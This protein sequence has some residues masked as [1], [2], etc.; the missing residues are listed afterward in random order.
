M[1]MLKWNT[2]F[3]YLAFDIFYFFSLNYFILYKCWGMKVSYNLGP[4]EF[5]V[6]FPLSG[7]Y[8]GAVLS[9]DGS[10]ILPLSPPGT[11]GES[12]DFL[13][14]TIGRVLLASTSGG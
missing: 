11:F 14:A 4:L 9:Q 13:I 5:S 2:I 6:F 1:K 12:A 3:L 7:A 8:K 10:G